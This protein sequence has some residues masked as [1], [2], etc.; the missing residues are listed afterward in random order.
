MT[1]QMTLQMTRW[2]AKS[3]SR[4]GPKMDPLKC[5]DCGNII[6][7]GYSS[8]P[9]YCHKCNIAHCPI[10]GGK[11]TKDTDSDDRNAYTNGH[12]KKCGFTCCGGCI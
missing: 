7:D 2:T 12:C 5:S 3:S 1:L 11:M 9:V 4:K 6:G 8:C 10:C